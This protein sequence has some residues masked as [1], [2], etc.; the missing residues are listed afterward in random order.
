[1]KLRTEMRRVGSRMELFDIELNTSTYPT[2]EHDAMAAHALLQAMVDCR[3]RYSS[4]EYAADQTAEHYLQSTLE[5]A[6]EILA[7]WM[8]E[9]RG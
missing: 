1:M 6:A 2:V 8:G 5:R 4:L 9:E 7:G 3:K